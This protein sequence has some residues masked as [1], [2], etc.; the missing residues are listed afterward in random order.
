MGLAVVD[1]DVADGE[2]VGRLDNEFAAKCRVLFHA[3]HDRFPEISG[4]CDFNHVLSAP[5]IPK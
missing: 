4:E 5:A 2:E 1:E 3:R